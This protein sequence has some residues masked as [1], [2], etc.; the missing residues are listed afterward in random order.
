MYIY[1][2]LYEMAIEVHMILLIL[3]RFEI[4]VGNIVFQKQ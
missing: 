2:M 1:D 3:M 4:N